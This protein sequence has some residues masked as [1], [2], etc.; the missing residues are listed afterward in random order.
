MTGLACGGVASPSSGIVRHSILVLPPDVWGSVP[1][2]A[3]VKL[4]QRVTWALCLLV[5]DDTKIMFATSCMGEKSE[6]LLPA[7]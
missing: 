4:H 6:I 5:V 7:K 1:P 2:S 3:P